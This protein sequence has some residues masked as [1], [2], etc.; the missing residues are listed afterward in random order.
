MINK[1]MPESGDDAKVGIVQFPLTQKNFTNFI[2]GLLGEPQHVQGFMEGAFII[3]TKGIEKLYLTIM[4][5]IEQ[6]NKANLIEFIAKIYFAN[7]TNI[8][9]KGLDK[10]IAYRNIEDEKVIR[11]DLTWNLLITFEDK[12]SPEKQTIDISF[13]TIQELKRHKLKYF[14]RDSSII[15]D[16][17]YT[18]RTWG[19]DIENLVRAAIKSVL[20]KRSKFKILVK[21][22]NSALTTLIPIAIY[23]MIFA[24]NCFFVN[25]YFY[26]S[27]QHITDQIS[28]IQDTQQVSFIAKY[29]ASVPWYQFTTYNNLFLIVMLIVCIAFGF[30]LDEILEM[31]LVDNSYIFINDDD[32]NVIMQKISKEEGKQ[33]LKFSIA[34][35]VNVFCG[36]ISNF[37]FQ[38]I[39]HMLNL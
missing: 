8:T 16:I 6:Q 30:Y 38:A 7:D 26:K 18:A 1:S 35:I 13:K 3:D 2:C 25:K 23:I 28:Q 20:V 4:Q 15:Y 32:K 17:S 10:L 24:I 22:C 27:A 37:I 39:L 12:E 21:K 5:R 36:I 33:K 31:V 34:L 29:I 11:L 9:I 14:I 19:V